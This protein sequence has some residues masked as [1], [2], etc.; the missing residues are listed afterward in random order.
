MGDGLVTLV[1]PLAVGIVMLGLG[2]TL[3]L[4]DFAH[5]ARY[6]RAVLVALG[7]QLVL[8]PL[9]CFGLVVAADPA[10]ELAVGMMLLAASPGGPLSNLFS[11]L[12]GGDVALNITLAAVNSV[13]SVVTLPLVVNLSVDHFLGSSADLGLQADKVAQVFAIVLVPVA[14]GMLARRYAPAAAARAERKVKV[15]SLVVL[16]VVIIGAAAQ[17]GSELRAGL[18]SVAPLALLF[19]LV[20]LTV[21][22]WLPRLARVGER[23]AVA[24]AL[25]IGLHNGAIAIAIALS[26]ALLDS[27][28]MALPAA[29]YGLLAF[30]PAGLFVAWRVRRA[31]AAPVRPLSTVGSPRD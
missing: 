31:P 7:C 21:G 3:T 26:P 10:P 22:Y 16:I 19:C 15:A 25:E 14:L 28:E 27:P 6:P 18:T 20:S 9:V 12:A 1:L 30:I 13:I 5:V 11:H 2:L 8:L 24:S 17:N 4:A 29:V 23:Q